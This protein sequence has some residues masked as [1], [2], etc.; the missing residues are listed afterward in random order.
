MKTLIELY[1][2]RP[3]ENILATEVF[4]PEKTVFLCTADVAQNKRIK[5]NI[6]SYLRHRGVN[7]EPVFI[8]SSLYDT[9]K[10]KAEVASRQ[11]RILGELNLANA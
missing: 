4:R 8:E 9:E 7:T 11:T 3:V 5:E 1:D 10:I 6:R 2:E